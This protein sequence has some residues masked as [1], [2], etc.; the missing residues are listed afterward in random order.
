MEQVLQE[1]EKFLNMIKQNNDYKRSLKNLR[2]KKS[3][4]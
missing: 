2:G 1:G 4:R 3:V